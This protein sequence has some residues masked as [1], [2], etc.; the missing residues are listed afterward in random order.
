MICDEFDLRALFRLCPGLVSIG[1][2]GMRPFIDYGEIGKRLVWYTMLR[3]PIK[4]SISMYQ[5][6][7]ERLD[8]NRTFTDW[9]Q[10]P[11]NN[12][13]HVRM[14]AGEQNLELA[15]ETLATR[16]RCVGLLEHFNESMLL[17]RHSMNWEGLR[18]SYG[19]P[20]NPARQGATAQ[21]IGDEFDRY[22]DMIQE[23]NRLDLELYQWV[24]G[25]LFPAQ[26]KRYGER[27]LRSDLETEFIDVPPS[28][29]EGSREFANNVFRRWIYMPALRVSRW[30]T[31]QS[32]LA[33]GIR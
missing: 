3:D 26:I 2:H 12:N 22:R 24:Q 18:V 27:Q 13:W 7:V 10:L 33:K 16:F 29:G 20:R 6:R 1:G 15:K 28:F 17:L 30:T 5:H 23:T 19:K 4:R 9:M 11:H 31:P 21:R 32:L 14:L 25:E 8:A